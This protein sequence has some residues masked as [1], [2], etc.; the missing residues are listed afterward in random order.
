MQTLST[1]SYLDSLQF[2]TTIA[3]SNVNVTIAQNI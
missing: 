3:V 2:Q 1:L